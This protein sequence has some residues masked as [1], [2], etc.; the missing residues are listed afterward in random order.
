MGQGI[1]IIGETGTGKSRAIKTLDPETTF[2]IKIIDKPLPFRGGKKLYKKG[3][4]KVSEGNLFV[5][6]SAPQIIG[7]MKKISS[8]MPHIKTI[9]VDDFQY[10]MSYEYM[11]RC[12][13]NGWDKFTDIGKRAFDVFRMPAELR[14]DLNVYITS[15]NF[16]DGKSSTIM[17]IGKSLDRNI[18]LQ[19]IYTFVF[20]TI[21]TDGNY[22]FLTKND[23]YHVAKTPDDMF[24][25]TYIDNDLGMIDLIIRE[26]DL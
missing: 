12:K 10:L 9:V 1:L 11:D 17:T 7:L 13:E 3:E 23:G 6:R 26:Y 14:E 15:H 4:E 20:H 8:D 22:Q 16:D 24:E 25:S 2:L 21:V 18:K 5:S 19:G